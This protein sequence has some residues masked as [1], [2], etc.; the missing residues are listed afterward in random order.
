MIRYDVFED[1]FKRI[2][3]GAFYGLPNEKLRFLINYE[4]RG[5]YTDIPNG[6]DD[7]LYIQMQIVF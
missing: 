6:H 2:T 1:E 3:F 5:L 4:Y 7:R